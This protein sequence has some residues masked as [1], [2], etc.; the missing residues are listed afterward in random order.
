MD[1]V[2]EGERSEGE[3]KE[4][5]PISWS[6]SRRNRITHTSLNYDQYGEETT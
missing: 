3:R 1:E 6:S 4:D 2:C 5:C